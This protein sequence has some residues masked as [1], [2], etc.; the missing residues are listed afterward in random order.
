MGHR[1]MV[2]HLR[3]ICR[4]FDGC[5]RYASGA[6]GRSPLRRGRRVPV[7]D[8]PPEMPPGFKVDADKKSYRH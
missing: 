5:V 7:T 2:G 8:D 4:R 6:P 3:M 1:L